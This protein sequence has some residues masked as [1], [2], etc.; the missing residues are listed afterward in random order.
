MR[1]SASQIAQIRQA[2]AEFAG[3]GAV[4]KLFGSRTDNEGRGGD[5]DLLVECAAP[6]AAPALV[7]ARIGGRISRYM[8]GRKVDVLLSAPNLLHS[9]LHEAA[10]RRGVLL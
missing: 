4:V 6:V 5:V 10:R 3:S 9:T 2:V 7:A 8:A 1:L